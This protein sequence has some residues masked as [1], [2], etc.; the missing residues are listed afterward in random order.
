MQWRRMLAAQNGNGITVIVIVVVVVVVVVAVVFFLFS[1]VNL[2]HYC[3]PCALLL[4][5]VVTM[6]TIL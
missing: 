4:S 6:P 3:R 2:M 1:Y 5:L